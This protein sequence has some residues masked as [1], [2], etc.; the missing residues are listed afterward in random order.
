MRPLFERLFFI[1][2][3]ADSI[4]TV[5]SFLLQYEKAKYTNLDK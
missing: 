5:Y 4:K 3:R 2:K 1:V